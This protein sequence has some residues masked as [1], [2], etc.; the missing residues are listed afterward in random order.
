M[1]VAT[2][3][4]SR[5]A[6][7]SNTAS[8]GAGDYVAGFRAGVSYLDS[9]VTKATMAPTVH[10]EATTVL[11]VAVPTTAATVVSGA[12]VKVCGYGSK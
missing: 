5:A 12:V 4:G 1:V 11:A 10:V 7:A 6:K 9:A 2:L 8:V 3:A